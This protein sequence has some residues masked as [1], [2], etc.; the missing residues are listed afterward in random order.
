MPMSITAIQSCMIFGIS[1]SFRLILTYALSCRYAIFIYNS[2]MLWLSQILSG[3]RKSIDVGVIATFERQNL[4]PPPIMVA[5]SVTIHAY[6]HLI[7]RS[8]EH[9]IP[10]RYFH[11]LSCL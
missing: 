8:L 4:L 6:G 9:P 11:F 7:G 5:L 2:S 10:P 1:T 3:S